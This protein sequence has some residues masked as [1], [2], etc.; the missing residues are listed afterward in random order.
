MCRFIW[1]NWNLKMP[2]FSFDRITQVMGE[3]LHRK[4]PQSV[5]IL[6]PVI[7][8]NCVV[9][10]CTARSLCMFDLFVQTWQTETV[11]FCGCCYVKLDSWG[12][13]GLSVNL[14][15]PVSG[16]WSLSCA[17]S[18]SAA[19]GSISYPHSDPH[20]AATHTANAGKGAPLRG[21]NYEFEIF[22]S[23]SWEPRKSI[24]PRSHPAKLSKVHIGAPAPNG[25]SSRY[26][27]LRDR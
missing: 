14:P 27:F 10:Y 13:L 21:N 23:L 25:A 20:L 2:E 7:K 11:Q 15:A 4:L 18:F 12:S 6:H 26:D 9:S 16:L 17:L 22:V 24:S 8:R 19:L 5:A 1:E 3:N